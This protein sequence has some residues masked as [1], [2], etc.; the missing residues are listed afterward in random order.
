MG[1]DPYEMHV[2]QTWVILT[3]PLL[4]TGGFFRPFFKKRKKHEVGSREQ[5]S[6]RGRNGF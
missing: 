1:P 5:K 6:R 3:T 4:L 2:Y